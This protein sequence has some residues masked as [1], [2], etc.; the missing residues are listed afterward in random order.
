MAEKHKKN[1]ERIVVVLGGAL[2]KG[3]NGN[4]RTTNFEVGDNF[5]ICGGRL[6]IVAAGLLYKNK[7]DQLIIASGGKGQLKNSLPK[8]ITIAK[9]ME[10]E[11]IK[12]G[13]PKK[14]I[15]REEKSNNTFGQ[16]EEIQKIIK[17]GKFKNILVISNRY[18]L[19]RLKAMLKYVPKLRWLKRM[20]EAKSLKIKSAEN[21][22]IKYQ[23]KLWRRFIK[24]AYKSDAMKERIALERRGTRDIKV[25]VYHLK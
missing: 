7:P 23:P 21:I 11:L 14:N 3:K 18:H 17:T 19:P 20:H 15:I 4:W 9:V 10:N 24:A 16:L 1:Q 12:A 25:G 8:N 5:G 6:R 22:A 13:I 2:A